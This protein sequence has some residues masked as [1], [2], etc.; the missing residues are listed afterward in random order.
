MNKHPSSPLIEKSAAPKDAASFLRHFLIKELSELIKMNGQPFLKFIPLIAGI[1]FLGACYDNRP[2][3][4]ER[5]S[6]KRFKKA[7]SLMGNKYQ[8]FDGSQ[9]QKY[10]CLYEDFRCPMIHQF[11]TNQDKFRLTA[12]QYDCMDNERREYH[13]S[14]HEGVYI[15]VLE[16]LYKDFVTA[17]N[18]TI[19]DIKNKKLNIGKLKESHVVIRDMEIISTT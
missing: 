6:K 12:L 4:E 16:E 11:R 2:F 14:F 19:D 5:W 7:I 17:V 15:I 8:R 18:K 10:P 13:L 1:E 9:R 3:D